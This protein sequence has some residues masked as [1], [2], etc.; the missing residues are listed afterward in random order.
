MTFNRVLLCKVRPMNRPDSTCRYETFTYGKL[1]AFVYRHVCCWQWRIQMVEQVSLRLS[2]L[3][4]SR[5]TKQE[6][7]QNSF[8]FVVFLLLFNIQLLTFWGL[9]YFK[10]G[11]Q[12]ISWPVITYSTMF[13]HFPFLS[14]NNQ[15][16]IVRWNSRRLCY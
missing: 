5:K 7:K 3:G 12:V 4:Q 2:R 1:S 10:Y 13:V 14:F 16:L 8:Q 6:Q 15:E 11:H 9:K